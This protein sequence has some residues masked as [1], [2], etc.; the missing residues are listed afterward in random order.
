MVLKREDRK[1]MRKKLKIIIALLTAFLLVGVITTSAIRIDI[2]E[3][4]IESDESSILNTDED[5]DFYAVI[6]ACSEYKNTKLN[7][8][9]FPFPPIASWKLK[10]FYQSII[11]TSNW[12]EENIILLLNEDATKQNLISAFNEMATKVDSNDIFM[13]SWQGHGGEVPDE[14][15]F[16]EEDETDESICLHDIGRD[17]NDIMQGYMTDDELN[18]HLSKINAKGMLLIFESCLSGG[19]SGEEFDVDKD[20]RIIIMSTLEDTI[21]R[22]SLLIGFPITMGLAVASNQKYKFHAEDKNGDGFISAEEIFNWAKYFIFAE[23]SVYWIT[24]WLD[25]ILFQGSKP[26]EAI[27]N[28]FIAFCINQITAF[29]MSGHFMFTCPNMIDN[30]PGELKIIEPVPAGEIDKTPGLPIEIWEE[31]NEVPWYLLDTEYWP[32]LLADIEILEQENT[33]VSLKGSA[34]NGPL[35]YSYEW[36][37]GDGAIVTGESITHTYNKKGTYEVKLKVTDDADRVEETT[38]SV[39]VEKSRERIFN[40]FERFSYLKPL[41]NYFSCKS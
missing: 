23:L 24:V 29:L 16:D 10:S 1:R 11:S 3:K 4:I 33:M 9:K 35:P 8:P 6:A 30:Y 22:A 34:C 12:K 31:E 28:T 36:D 26:I 5:T 2:P 20:N 32:K 19:L 25:H 41:L 21:G 15:P 14:E 40:I 27:I 38:I 17:E 37:L 18:T 39:K 7:I 13:F